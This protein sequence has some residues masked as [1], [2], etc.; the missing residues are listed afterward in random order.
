MCLGGEGVCAR[1]LCV[2][3]LLCVVEFALSLLCVLVACV[4][5][6]QMGHPLLYLLECFNV[7]IG[8]HTFCRSGVCRLC[9][10]V[11]VLSW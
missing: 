2:L 3:C 7:L 5:R 8:L 11:Y 4:L 9:V 1:S 10:C 6:A